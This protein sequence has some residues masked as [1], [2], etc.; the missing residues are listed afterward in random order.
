MA[1][2]EEPPRQAP[3]GPRGPGTQ[4]CRPVPRVHAFGKGGQAL[5]RDPRA[6]PAMRG[7]LHKQDSSGLRLWKRRWFVLVD[8]C[9]YYYRDSGEQRVRGGLPLP[10]YEIRVLPLAP[11]APR[12]L[13]TA[14]HPGMRTY[15]LGAETPE[16]LNA[17]VC[18]LRRGASPLPGSPRSLPLQ[19]P[20][21]HWSAGPPSPPLPARSP[22][23]F[24][25]RPPGEELEAPPTPPP[26]HPLVPPLPPSQEEAP[27]RAGPCGTLD[28]RGQPRG[29]AVGA[30]AAAAGRSPQKLRLPGATTNQQLPP[31]DGRGPDT[32]EE[33]VAT[34]QTLSSPSGSSDWLLASE[35]S[36]GAL[37]SSGNASP[38][39][40]NETSL[41]PRAGA[42]GRGLKREGVAGHG[43]RRPIRITLL[44]AS[45]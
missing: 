28:P 4:P 13:F 7:W 41:W 23:W 19:A 37:P 26:R 38:P 12:F 27:A 5:R 1:D 11:R 32:E 29:P 3:A 17:W 6:P 20:Q 30:A 31:L 14:E 16:E 8:L 24:S 39:A 18:A 42:S 36:D 43:A 10:G 35:G 45:F 25:L 15:C 2:G 34:N 22:G 40:A 9:L 33:D 21:D 44:Q